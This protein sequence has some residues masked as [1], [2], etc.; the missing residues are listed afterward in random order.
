MS[1][2]Q[3]GGDFQQLNCQGFRFSNPNKPVQ[4]Y[5]SPQTPRAQS[6]I[7]GDSHGLTHGGDIGTGSFAEFQQFLEWRRHSES[8]SANSSLNSSFGQQSIRVSDTSHVPTLTST[9]N[10]S[11]TKHAK[12]KHKKRDVSSS[13]SKSSDSESS[14]DSSSSS[15]SDDSYYRK[16]K[17]SRRSRRKSRKK[18]HR[19]KSYHR[20]SRSRTPQ[21][22]NTSKRSRSKS[23]SPSPKTSAPVSMTVSANPPNPA[24]DDVSVRKAKHRKPTLETIGVTV[25]ANPPNPAAASVSVTKVDSVLGQHKCHRSKK[26][27][28]SPAVA[29]MT[30]KTEPGLLP[31]QSPIRIKQEKIPEPDKDEGYLT[32]RIKKEDLRGFVEHEGHV[33]AERKP[34]PNRYVYSY[35][36]LVKYGVH[37]SCTLDFLPGIH[38]TFLN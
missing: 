29:N 17:H 4:R 16:R 9:P 31:Q 3:G 34:Q 32:V 6:L 23:P 19:K 28:V 37:I 26:A 38:H 25:G 20:R 22:K 11:K 27:S 30:V 7:M 18:S 13:S 2:N 1:T 10:D 21:Q 33:L 14:S 15:E 12:R 24:A 5:V 36:V 35:F 8:I